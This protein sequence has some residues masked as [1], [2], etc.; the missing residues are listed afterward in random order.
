MATTV[1]GA[2]RLALGHWTECHCLDQRKIGGVR[3]LV[4]VI[5]ATVLLLAPYSRILSQER[6]PRGELKSK[7][8]G[9]IR[10]LD[11]SKAGVRQQ[12]QDDL[13][14][15][16]PV[17]LPLLPAEDNQS[18]SA[19]QVKRL[20]IVRE[21][22]I[23]SSAQAN[24]EGSKVTISAES[25]TLSDLI[26][27]IQ[28]QTGNEIVD[29]REQY[30]Q[31]V[32]NPILEI[33]WKDK[34][35]WEAMDELSDKSQVGFDLYTGAA[36]LGLSG[37][38]VPETPTTYAG[39]LRL[40]VKTIQRT[41]NFDNNQKSCALKL[42]VAWEPRLKPILL[43]FTPSELKVIDDQGREIAA[44]EDQLPPGAEEDGPR[45]FKVPANKTIIHT[46]FVY[47]F[48]PPEFDAK[49]I[50]LLRG[51][52][53][54]V[55]PALVQTFQFSNLAKSKNVKKTNRNLTITL[56]EFKEFDE[57]LWSADLL[58][59]FD[60]GSD[61]FESYQTWFYDNE[62]YLQR[63]DGT[64]FA[65]NGGTSL[66]ESNEGRVGIQYRFT[67]APGRISDYK[68]IYKTPSTIGK[69]TFSFEFRDLELP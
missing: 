19:E 69:Q 31:E 39:P 42:E 4:V 52:V 61:A 55:V 22:L 6:A 33:A 30:G 24:T 35:F 67:D 5:V 60:S 41:I 51:Q 9:L 14:R 66:T 68:L 49:S 44:E 28:K 29:M 23:R 7:V 27:T 8:M 17:A 21:A 38:P 3:S 15:L 65:V 47:R 40:A 2:S 50:K 59:E 11:A 54:V 48:E 32:T 46:D 43:E 1:R 26:G 18:L 37:R 45:T 63:A 58:L 20:K 64:R 25:I 13:I 36:H 12:A 53:N 34:P 57:G 62:I 10:T 56:Q 16:G